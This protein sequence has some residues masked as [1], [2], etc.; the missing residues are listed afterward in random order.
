M[1]HLYKMVEQGIYIHVPYIINIQIK[2][3]KQTGK[4]LLKSCGK[5][6]E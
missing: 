4:M 5:I 6:I 3:R 2:L 1:E